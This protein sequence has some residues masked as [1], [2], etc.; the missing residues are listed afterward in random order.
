LYCIV[1]RDFASLPLSFSFPSKHF[2][3]LLAGDTRYTEDATLASFADTVLESGCAYFCAWGPGC[4]RA[5]DIFD[6]QCL[7]AS[8]IM[9]T[10]HAEE[11]LDEA[12]WFFL[13]TTWPDD[14]YFDTCGSAIAITVG[15]TDS[16]VYI[17]RRLRDIPSLA[18]DVLSKI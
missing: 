7:F 9:T 12:L 5:H 18:R 8:P 16:A 6:A 14:T 2:V 11:P 17:E 13:R 3:A 10:W 1:A 4:E 15:D